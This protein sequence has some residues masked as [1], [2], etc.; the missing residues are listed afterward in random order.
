MSAH[1]LTIGMA[2][3]DDFEGVYF[4]VTSLMIHHAGAM[5]NCN[6]LVVDNNPASRHGRLIK[7]WIAD[8]APQAEYHPFADATGTAQ[9]RNEVFRRAT[10]RAV[11]CI[12]CHVLLAPGAVRRLLDYYAANPNTRDLLTGPLLDDSGQVAATHQ[13]PQWSDG[14]WGVWALD[15]RA[16]QPDSEPFPNLAAGNGPLLPA[17][18]K[19]GSAFI[20]PFADSAAVNPTSWKNSASGAVRSSAVP[21]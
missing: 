5:D 12:D 15:D 11:L 17:G 4:T 21:G 10:G 7:K 6:V 13:R 1:A 20:P 16:Q 9:A 8:L 14:A 2:A 19:P 18:R 3:F